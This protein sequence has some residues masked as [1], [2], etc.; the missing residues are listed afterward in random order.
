[1]QRRKIA[2]CLLLSLALTGSAAG[3]TPGE[4]KV[5]EAWL[6]LSETGP[7][8]VHIEFDARATADALYQRID[9]W[10]ILHREGTLEALVSADEVRQLTAEGFVLTLD[11]EKTR[12]LG[13]LGIPLAGQGGGIP[14]FP[15]Y[16]TVEETY[17]AA[18]AIV[19]AH[20]D[21]ASWNDVGDSWRRPSIRTT[22]GTSSSSA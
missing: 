3:Q 6:D 8:V 20:P 14:G 7:W 11:E 21:L 10:R 5:P 4:T 22:A 18:E 13:R 1:M 12:T 2:L 15:C 16:R 17:A 9:V 19:A